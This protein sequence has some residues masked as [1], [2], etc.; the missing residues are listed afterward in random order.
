MVGASVPLN[1]G[2]TVEK[3]VSIAVVKKV[4]FETNVSNYWFA[5]ASILL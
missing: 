3:I 5:R 2:I 1:I 4:D